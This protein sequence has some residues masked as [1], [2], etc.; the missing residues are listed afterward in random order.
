MVGRLRAR[1]GMGRRNAKTDTRLTPVFVRNS[2]HWARRS[3]MD[4]MMETSKNNRMFLSLFPMQCGSYPGRIGLI[5]YLDP[6]QSDPNPIQS[7]SQRQQRGMHQCQNNHQS[8]LFACQETDPYLFFFSHP[9]NAK[10]SAANL[11]ERLY[12]YVYPSTPR[13]MPFI[14]Q[15]SKKVTGRMLYRIRRRVRSARNDYRFDRLRV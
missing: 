6:I 1:A 2:S 10:R 14:I 4:H 5:M 15:C 8:T 13:I 9:Q 12:R 3:E 7:Q 11:L